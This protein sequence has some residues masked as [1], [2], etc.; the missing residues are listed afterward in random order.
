MKSKLSIKGL[1]NF[2]RENKKIS[3]NL[4]NKIVVMGNESSDMD[5]MISSLCYGFFLNT[6]NT[7]K[8]VITLFNIPRKDFGLRTESS[9]YFKKLGIE[10]DELIFIDEF[11]TKKYLDEKKLCFVLV[12]HNRLASSQGEFSDHVVEILDHHVDEN[13]YSST[14]KK[15]KIELV[16]SCATL[17]AEEILSQNE[18]EMEDTFIQLLL[19]PIIVDTNNLDPKS[20]KATPK[21]EEIVGKLLKLSNLDLPFLK[22]LNET[23]TFEK[24]NVK[25]LTNEQLFLKDYKQFDMKGTIVGI[26]AVQTSISD[27]FEKEKLSNESLLDLCSRFTLERKLDVL[28]VMTSFTSKEGKFVRELIVYVKDNKNL[29]DS[30]SS[31][32][33]IVSTDKGSLDLSKIE[34]P[35]NYPPFIS[36]YTQNNIQA[37]RKQIQPALVD[38][39]EK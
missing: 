17:V 36:L 6:I 8:E 22:S 15:K 33:S 27:M 30:I 23:L 18:V 5:S 24:F 21:D 28:V 37:S 14:L 38:F 13:K 12:D 4:N 26:P 1:N 11:D 3:N 2:L 29:H 25:S 31:H 7:S 16:G 20:G 32:F 19:A 35:Q 9:Y 34:A 39:F 10:T